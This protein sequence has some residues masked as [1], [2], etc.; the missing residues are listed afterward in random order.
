M[1]LVKN[2][3]SI[4][5]YNGKH[6][7]LGLLLKIIRYFRTFPIEKK[8]EDQ[9]YPI[10]VDGELVIVCTNAYIEWVSF[11]EW[12]LLTFFFAPRT[13]RITIENDLKNFYGNADEYFLGPLTFS[14]LF[15]LLERNR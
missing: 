11:F 13:F 3:I 2:C 15:N 5:L 6:K 14:N 7:P 9:L 4:D 12:N 8:V 10:A 1:N